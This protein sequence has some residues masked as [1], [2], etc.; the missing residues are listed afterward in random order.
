[1]NKQKRLFFAVNLPDKVKEEISKTILPK[2]PKEKWRTVKKENLHI[3]MRF[4]GHLPEQA[5]GELQEKTNVVG[6][7]E[8][9]YAELKGVGHF[10]NRILWIGTGEGT[11]EFNLLSKKL[12]EALGVLDKR[13]HAHITIAR[14]RGSKPKETD[15][16]IEG[17]RKQKFERRITV[18]SV[19]LMES[20]LHKAGPEYKKVF[21]TELKSRL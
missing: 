11:N 16:L 21:L 5:I 12:C 2:I 4:L 3:T 1:M 20:I 9:F 10:K 7:S 15:E 13:F 14:N 18:R 19:D 6:N 17:L 8:E